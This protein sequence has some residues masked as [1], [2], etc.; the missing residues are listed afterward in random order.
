DGVFVSGAVGD[1]GLGLRALRGELEALP[2]AHRAALADRYQLPEP[3][4]ALAAR[5]REEASAAIDVSDGLLADAG[6]MAAAS[7]VALRIDLE[8]I[9]VSPAAALWIA[10]EPDEAAARAW[11]ASAGDDYELLACACGP[12][13]A[14]APGFTRIGAVE[15]GEGARLVDGRGRVIDAPRRGFTHF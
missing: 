9:P 10:G 6:H 3:R 12:L 7:G 11:L 8:A 14:G 4:T 15:A 1:G 5:I 13:D 2:A